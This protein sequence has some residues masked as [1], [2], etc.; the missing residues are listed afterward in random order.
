MFKVKSVRQMSIKIFPLFSTSLLK[1]THR[2][3]TATASPRPSICKVANRYEIQTL[4]VVSFLDFSI[5]SS[6]TKIN[7]ATLSV[8]VMRPPF[9]GGPDD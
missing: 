8:G 2:I 1:R 7:W 4:S 3:E 6:E 9:R 5:P